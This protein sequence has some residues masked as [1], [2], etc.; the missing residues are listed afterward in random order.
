VSVQLDLPVHQAFLLRAHAYSS[1]R[2]TTDI[3][4]AWWIAGFAWIKGAAEQ[5]RPYDSS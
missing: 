2:S 5:S 1:R 3:A 4:Q